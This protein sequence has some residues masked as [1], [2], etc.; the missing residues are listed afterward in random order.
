L[1]CED[2]FYHFGGHAHAAGMQMP[3]ENVPVFAERLEKIARAA[4]D[5][6]GHEPV[7]DVCADVR[8]EDI[9]P[10]LVHCLQR[11]EPF[12]PGNRNPL[13][14]AQA[15]MDTGKS[16]LLNNNHV[17]LSLTHTPEGPAFKGVGF[18]LGETFSA[19][20]VKRPFDIIFNVREEEWQGQ[21]DVTLYVKAFRQEK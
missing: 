20:D 12:G 8:L 9:T 15:V 17:R 2:L 4:F 21:K 10:E 6:N 13:F 16:R 7:L 3:P 18:G 5:K 1:Q 19:L 14:T 11:F